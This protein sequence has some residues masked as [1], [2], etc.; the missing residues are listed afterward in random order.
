MI[1]ARFIEVK[2]NSFKYIDYLK[3]TG[4]YEYIPQIYR[5]AIRLGPNLKK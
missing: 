1:G 5:K 3:G 2:E 4:R